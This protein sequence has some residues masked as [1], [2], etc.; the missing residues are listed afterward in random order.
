VDLIVDSTG[1]KLGGQ[2][3]WHRQKHGGRKR[4]RWEKLH[5]GVDDQGRLS[6]PA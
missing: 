5:I 3:A 4:Q 1:V 2:G 6:R